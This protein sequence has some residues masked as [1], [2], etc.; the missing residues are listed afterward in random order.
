MPA[1]PAGALSPNAIATGQTSTALAIV[2]TIP[3]PRIFTIP[4]RM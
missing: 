1:S 3:T 4:E 2:D